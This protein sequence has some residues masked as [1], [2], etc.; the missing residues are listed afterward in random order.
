MVK[1]QKLYTIN[2]PDLIQA[3]SALISAAGAFDLSNNVLERARKLFETQGIAQKD[4]QQAVSDQQSAEG[5]LKAARNAVAIFGKTDAGIDQIII[6][7]LIDP[8]MVVSTF[9]LSI[10]LPW[11]RNSR[12]SILWPTGCISP[13]TSSC[14]WQSRDCSRWSSP[15]A[16]AGGSG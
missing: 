16:T 2:S 7:R 6:K 15:R 5:A 14:P 10:S 13:R 3:E 4:L 1:G 12:L 8:V 11:L 9:C